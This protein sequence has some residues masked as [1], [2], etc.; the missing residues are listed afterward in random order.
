VARLGGAWPGM[1][2]Q[3]TAGPGGAGQGKVIYGNQTHLR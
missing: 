2:R 3:G 1:A